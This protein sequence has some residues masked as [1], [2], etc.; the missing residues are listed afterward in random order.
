MQAL[1]I[2]YFPIEP[3]PA[4]FAAQLKARVLT[5]VALV[6]QPGQGDKSHLSPELKRLRRKLGRW[7]FRRFCLFMLI[8]ITILLFGLSF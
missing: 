2:K 5:E 4:D 6:I 3:L 1:F 8:N 7:F